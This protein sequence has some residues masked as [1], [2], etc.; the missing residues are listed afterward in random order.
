MARRQRRGSKRKALFPESQVQ[1]AALQWLRLFHPLARE[2]VIKID[3]EGKRTPAGHAL[4]I[5]LGLH[6]G[7]SDLFI[8]WP[9]PNYPGLWLEV[10][11]PGFKVTKS[12]LEH[13]ESQMRF[14][15]LMRSRGYYADM[16]IG[17]DQCISIIKNYLSGLC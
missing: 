10:K 4:A 11:P 7:A 2:C 3:N 12:K 13:Y 1:K 17:I 15:N 16:G 5:E 14:I 6:K 8:A 9:T